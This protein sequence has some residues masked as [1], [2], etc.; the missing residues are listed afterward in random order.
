VAKVETFSFAAKADW[1]QEALARGC[2]V[3]SNELSCF[4]AL[5]KVGCIHHPVIVNGRHP[6]D[7]LDFRYINTLISNLKTSV[8]G[9][10]QALRFVK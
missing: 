6:K 3:I 2:E 8:R 1:A 4:R 10:F 5:A 9:L 7:I